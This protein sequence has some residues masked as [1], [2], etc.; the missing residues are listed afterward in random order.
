[1]NMTNKRHQLQ[2]LLQIQNYIKFQPKHK[3]FHY[4]GNT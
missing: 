2:E 1:M 3:G 4:K